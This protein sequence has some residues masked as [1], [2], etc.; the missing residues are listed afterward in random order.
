MIICPKCGREN[1]EGSEFCQYCGAALEPQEKTKRNENQIE[2]QGRMIP[3]PSFLEG[4]KVLGEFKASFWDI[5]LVGFILRYRERIVV[6]TRRIF[7]FSRGITGERLKFLFLRDVAA[8]EA[9]SR[10]SMTKFLVGIGLLIFGIFAMHG[11]SGSNYYGY[12]YS[13]S[14]YGMP[15]YIR[16]LIILVG[17]FLIWIARKKAFAVTTQDVKNSIVFSFSKMKKEQAKHFIDIV[18][19]ASENLNSRK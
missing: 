7:H 14:S 17:L 10:F 9:G 1:E 19:Q 4:E 16:L 18:S 11:S 5:G 8:V 2:S 6:T 13:Y 3:S 15:W 12:S